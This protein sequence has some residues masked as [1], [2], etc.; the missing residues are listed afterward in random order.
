VSPNDTAAEVQDGV[1]DWLRAG[2]RVLWLLYPSNRNV[3]LFRGLDH[4]ERRSGDDEL[5]AEPVL[6]DSVVR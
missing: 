5:D 4:V 1:D 2:P 3:L 6:P